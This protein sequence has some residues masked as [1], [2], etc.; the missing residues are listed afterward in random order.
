MRP[1]WDEFYGSAGRAVSAVAKLGGQ[2]ALH[3]YLTPTAKDVIDAR[4]TAEGFVV[5]DSVT[6]ENISFYY[7]HGL[8]R[9]KFWRPTSQLSP[10]QVKDDLVLRYGMLESTAV[11]NADYAVFDP[12]NVDMPESFHHNGSTANHLALVLNRYEAR[13]LLRAAESLPLD[14]VAQQ[15]AQQERAEVV[16]IKCGPQGALVWHSG[17]ATQVP[18]YETTKVW[19]I[20]SGDQFAANFAYAWMEERRDPVEAADRASR[21]TAFYCQH[22]GFPTAAELDNYKP[23]PILVS[24]DYKNGVRRKV[25]LAGPFFTLGELWV[26]DQARRSLLDMGLDVFSPYHDVG[27]GDAA[28]VVPKDIEGIRDCDLLLAIMDGSDAGTVFEVGFAY[29]DGK[30]VIVYAEN[31]TAEN[32]KMMVGSG[33]FMR[34]DFVSAIYKTGWVAASL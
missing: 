6:I 25:Y 16:V 8:A 32:C 33:C 29:R 11:V 3:C 22:L 17:K 26:V 31:E 19:K 7:E 9:P 13:A 24:G 30:P 2:A 10:L 28:D 1:N 23:D 18:A 5:R 4:K 15:L 20:G 34:Q 12:Q 21:A 27:P 14:Q